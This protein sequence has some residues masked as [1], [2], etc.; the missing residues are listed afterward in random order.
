VM[1]IYKGCSDGRGGGCDADEDAV[2]DG[3]KEAVDD[4]VGGHI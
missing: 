1:M 4:V 3:G 2:D